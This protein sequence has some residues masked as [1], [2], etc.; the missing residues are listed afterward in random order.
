MGVSEVMAPG[1]K[2]EISA[3]IGSL[4]SNDY[5]P[6]K[7]HFSELQPWKNFS[8]VKRIPIKY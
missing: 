8:F 1:I 6:I 7:Y 4:P 3:E 2:H 5:K